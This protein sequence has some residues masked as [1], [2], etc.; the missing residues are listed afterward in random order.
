MFFNCFTIL[1]LA[2]AVHGNPVPNCG[3][4]VKNPRIVNGVD[5]KAG[6]WPWMTRLATTGYYL[7]CGGTL[8]S[9]RWVLSAAHCFTA[10]DK[11][12][13][14]ATLGDL[15]ITQDEEGEQIRNV[16]QIIRH[17][18]Y[19]DNT[20]DNDYLLIEL[21]S[22]VTITDHVRPACLPFGLSKNAFNNATRAAKMRINISFTNVKIIIDVL[23]RF[24]SALNLR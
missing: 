15:T 13:L 8:I 5:S 19:N 1:S 21:D 12:S 22:P 4:V 9:D 24:Q 16:K 14:T 6:R 3:T 20:L 10:A 17:P 11:D 2:L 23:K 18:Q 7:D